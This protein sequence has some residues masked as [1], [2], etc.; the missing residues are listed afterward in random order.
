MRHC[1]PSRRERGSAMMAILVLVVICG[2]LAYAS[3]GPALARQRE[4]QTL[5]QR[6]RAFQVAE[7]GI[8]WGIAQIRST[9][10]AIPTPSTVVRSPDSGSGGQFSVTYTAGNTNGVDDDG[11]GTADDADERDLVEIVS[12]GDVNGHRRTLRVMLRRS[13]EVPKLEAAIQFN[14]ENPILDLSGNAFLVSGFEH[15]LNGTEDSTRPPFAG[16]AAPGNVAALIAQVSSKNIDQIEGLGGTPSLA[17]VD[18][19]DLDTLV[20]QARAAANVRLAGGTHAGTTTFGA[21]TEAGVMVV[22]AE[23]DVHLSGQT[24]GYGI[25]VVDGDLRSSGQ[26]IW[27]GIVIVRGRVTFTGGGS[28]KRIVGSLVIGEEISA[29]T[30]SSEMRISGT[31]DLFFST[32]SVE[33]AQTRLAI[34]TVLSWQEVA[35][36]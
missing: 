10:G 17:F 16:I 1:I 31:V 20:E 4:A 29:N 3:L 15:L 14:V 6:E 25:L 21:P 30:N 18:P 27:T 22:V 9:R 33:L 5:I 11:D 32:D 2:A 13:V 36:P 24:T 12:T 8:D 7:A 28:G 35:N 26:F 23:D 19:I 34:M